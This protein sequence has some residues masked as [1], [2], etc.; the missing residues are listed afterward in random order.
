MSS[1]G[2]LLADVDSLLNYSVIAKERKYAIKNACT[3]LTDIGV[4]KYVNVI[5]EVWD[6]GWLPESCSNVRRKLATDLVSWCLD[7]LC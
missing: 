1:H 4:D 5:L 6:F 7:K 3:A 2:T